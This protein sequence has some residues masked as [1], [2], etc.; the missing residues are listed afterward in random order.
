MS[1]HIVVLKQYV[2][3]IFLVAFSVTL[4]ALA[5]NLWF[6]R[7]T[8]YGPERVLCQFGC[9]SVPQPPACCFCC[10]STGFQHAAT[11]ELAFFNV[12]ILVTCAPILYFFAPAFYTFT[13]M[14]ILMIYGAITVIGIAAMFA[15]K[16]VGQ[17]QW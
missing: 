13:G 8:N 17:K 16:L 2:I 10:T 5:L 9:C 1:I 14:E 11:L 12:G 6:G 4:F 7:R 15:L 3:P